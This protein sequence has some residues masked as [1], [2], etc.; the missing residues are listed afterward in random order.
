MRASGRFTQHRHP[1]N[2]VMTTRKCSLLNLGVW[3]AGCIIFIW[4][5]SSLDIR[6]SSPCFFFSTATFYEISDKSRL[7]FVNQSGSRAA[8]PLVDFLRTRSVSTWLKLPIFYFILYSMAKVTLLILKLQFR[9]FI[10]K[11]PSAISFGANTFLLKE[12]LSWE[13]PWLQ[14]NHVLSS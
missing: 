5:L 2:S 9:L 1:E 6:L 4:N 14:Q 12:T 8:G 11:C 3:Q 7:M 10:F 13:V